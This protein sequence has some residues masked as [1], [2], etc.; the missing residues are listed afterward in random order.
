MSVDPRI[1]QFVS[2]ANEFAFQNKHLMN[3]PVFNHFFKV[4]KPEFK[5]ACIKAFEAGISADM[6]LPKLI[7]ENWKVEKFEA[8]SLGERTKAKVVR[9]FG[10]HMYMLN[11]ANKPF[12]NGNPSTFDFTEIRTKLNALEESYK[13][14]KTETVVVGEQ[15]LTHSTFRAAKKGKNGKLGLV[16]F[17]KANK[18]MVDTKEK[19]IELKALLT[20]SKTA[21]KIDTMFKKIEKAKEKAK[22]TP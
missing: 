21:D 17:L 6:I 2:L 16:K 3:N 20:D 10:K 19:V 1:N 18:D 11:K 4:A 12:A 13:A 9:Y 14:I 8:S 22:A 15:T 7:G 5:N